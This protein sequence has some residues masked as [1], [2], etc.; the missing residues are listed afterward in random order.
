[1]KKTYLQPTM[2]VV[3]LNSQT[4]LLSTSQFP[5]RA[6]IIDEEGDDNDYD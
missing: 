6:E 4:I 3:V 2:K 5:D 1:M